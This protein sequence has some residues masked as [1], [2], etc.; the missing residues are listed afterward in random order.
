MGP[1]SA[2]ELI[3][4]PSHLQPPSEGQRRSLRASVS[5]YSS[6]SLSTAEPGARKLG[7]PSAQALG[8]ESQDLPIPIL[9]PHLL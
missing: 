2:G 6:V 4:A 9:P 3:L 8:E 5:P 1:P 7:K